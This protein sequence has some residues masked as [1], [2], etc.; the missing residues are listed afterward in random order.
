MHIRRNHDIRP[1]LLKTLPRPGQNFGNDGK[2]GISL[3]GK[4]VDQREKRRRW[5]QCF[6]NDSQMR[7]PSASQRF[8]IGSQLIRS[9]QQYAP[10]LQQ[11]TPDVSEFC[12]VA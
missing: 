4:S 7:F 2:L 12:T 3:A 1:P 6:G 9:F 11:H 10:T 8:G 5:H